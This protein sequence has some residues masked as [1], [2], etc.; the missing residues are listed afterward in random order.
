M[1]IKSI[2]FFCENSDAYFHCILHFNTEKRLTKQDIT[3]PK[4]NVYLAQKFK[5]WIEFSNQR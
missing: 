3:C 5:Q 2:Y 1:V 4:K